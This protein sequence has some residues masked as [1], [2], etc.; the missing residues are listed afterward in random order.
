MAS[1][2]P[3]AHHGGVTALCALPGRQGSLAVSAGKD[4]QLALWRLPGTEAVG[5]AAG[6]GAM[7]RPQARAWQQL[8]S[9]SGHKAAIECV[10]P[11]PDGASIASGGW[12]SN[13]FVWR[14][15]VHLQQIRCTVSWHPPEHLGST[16]MLLEKGCRST[17]LH[18]R[19]IK[20]LL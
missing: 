13:L 10:A 16:T 12:D 2:S 19:E 11:S 6:K 4:L 20:P 8:A 5:A 1:C 3:M 7:G 9:Y 14:S 15:G 17:K 18:S